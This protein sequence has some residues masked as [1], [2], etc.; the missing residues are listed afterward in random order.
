MPSAYCLLLDPY[1]LGILRN[2]TKSF[3]IYKK[4]A[5]IKVRDLMAIV[6]L[7]NRPVDLIEYKLQI[8]F[9]K[10]SESY[11]F[12][13]RL[14]SAAPKGTGCCGTRVK[15]PGPTD[16]S[17]QSSWQYQSLL[18]HPTPA[19]PRSLQHALWFTAALCIFWRGPFSL[20]NANLRKP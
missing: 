2:S 6:F 14:R 9:R 10:V 8:S 17:A 12:L 7:A 5:R 13:Q 11:D 1:L 3:D 20:S 15:K 4:K 18:F 16:R 19:F